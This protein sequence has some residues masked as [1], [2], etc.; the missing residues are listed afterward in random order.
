METNAQDL[1]GWLA[2]TQDDVNVG[3][4]FMQ[5]EKDN[6]IKFLDAWVHEDHRRKGIFR[7]LWDTRWKF[8]QQ[9]YSG[10][11]AYAWCLPMSLPLLLEKGFNE[12]DTCVYVQKE[13]RL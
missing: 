3:H 11:I 13:I 7:S 6:K 4:I 10:W 9:N 12:G 2:V 1:I 8:V 5:L